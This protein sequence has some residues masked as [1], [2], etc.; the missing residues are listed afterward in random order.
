MTDGLSSYVFMRKVIKKGGQHSL[1]NRSANIHHFSA[2]SKSA[3]RAVITKVNNFAP[4]FA[5]SKLTKRA[6]F[7]TPILGAKFEMHENK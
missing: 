7:A 6:I 5:I 1:L 4:T 2:I 3:F